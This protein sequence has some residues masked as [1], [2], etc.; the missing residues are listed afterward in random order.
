MFRF[1]DLCSGI[2]GMRVSAEMHGGKCIFSSEINKYAKETYYNNFGE[3]PE[4]D[5]FKINPLDIPSHD[6]LLAGFPCQPFSVAGKMNGFEDERSN[7]FLKII[8]IINL[9]KPNYILLE[10]VKNLKTHDR[11]NT[12]NKIIS[13]LKNEGYEVQ[14]FI[15]NSKDF[16]LAQNRERIII[17]CSK[18]N[19]SIPNIRTNNKSK[20]VFIKDILEYD[21]NHEYLVNSEYTILSEYK[22]QKSGIIFCGYL[23]KNLRNNIDVEKKHLSRVHRQQNRIHYYEGIHP[24][25]NSSEKSG[26]YYIYDNIGVRKLTINEVYRLQG[27]SDEFKK[28][29]TKTHAYEQIGNSV[30][31]NLI[32]NIIGQI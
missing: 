23:N 24:T 20:S 14:T 3:I 11:G 19:I 2:G 7:V 27:F 18:N 13:L 17:L 26:R 22:T 21:K 10:N 9:C 25:L 8:N 30:S 31:I 15:L 5:I 29:K 6:L 28:H 16:E 4:G 32:E 1:I 12:Y